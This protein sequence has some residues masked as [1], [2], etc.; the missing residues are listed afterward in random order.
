MRRKTQAYIAIFVVLILVLLSQFFYTR[1]DVTGD[2]R[3]SFSE[4]T[5]QVLKDVEH[6]ID[7]HVF[8]DGDL[9]SNFKTL[10]NETRFLLNEIQRINPKISFKFINPIKENLSIDSLQQL[11]VTDVFVPTNDKILRV[12][13]FATLQYEKKTQAIALLSN[14][15]IPIDER[16]LS[17]INQIEENLVKEIY[18]LTRNDRKKVGLIVHHDELMPQYLDGMLKV[19]S[20]DYDVEAYTAPITNGSKTLSA[21]DLKP[22]EKF[23]AL[24]IAK[25]VKAFTDND[26]LVLDQY[27]MNG[28]KTLW[29]TENVDAEMDSLFRSDKIVSFPR[30]LKINDLLFSY[31]VRVLPSV[32]KDLQSAYITLAIG[33]VGNNTAYEQYPW[34]YF[35]L[36]IPDGKHSITKKINNPIR[37][38]FANPI[39]ILPRDSVEAKVLLTTSPNTQLQKPLSYIDFNEINKTTPENYPAQSGVYPLA[40][41]L[42]GKFKSAYAGRYESREIPDFKK[43][44]VPNKMIIIS[45]GDFAKNHIFRGQALPLGADKY[46]LRPDVATQANVIYG[47]ASFI[48]NSLDYLTGDTTKI[49]LNNKE[50][51]TYLLDKNTVKAEQSTWRWL[52]LLFPLALL[53]ILAAVLITWHK[54]T[55]TQK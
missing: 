52:N 21:K 53:G 29:M 31:G 17:S 38:E 51:N 48:L 14:K 33:Q 32:V 49:N 54:K 26:K 44:S 11:G 10:K 20:K 19:I 55:F 27:I 30:E 16:A 6:P 45:D 15:K 2:K 23:D 8:L 12:F 39:E 24:I 9:T 47:N 34:P 7:I 5:K 41:L 40:V 18:R 42:E 36:S 37:F 22:L 1:W 43:R 50:R 25:P 46:S 28:G 3:F 13:P 35:P 4:T